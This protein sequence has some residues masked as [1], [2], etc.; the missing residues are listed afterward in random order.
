MKESQE[1]SE[2][3]RVPPYLSVAKLNKLFDLLST[4]S[5]AQITSSDLMAR[6][7]SKQDSFLAVQTLKFFGLLAPGGRT[8]EDIRLF[9]M[10]GPEKVEKLQS[11]FRQSYKKIFDTVPNAEK[12]TKNELHDELMASYKISHRLATPA[13]LAFLW[14]CGKF[15]LETTEGVISRPKSKVELR[16]SVNKNRGAG[17]ISQEKEKPE[18]VEA[19]DKNH[20]DMNISDTGIKVLFPKDEKLEDAIVSGDFSEARLKIIEFAKKVGLVKG[21]RENKIGSEQD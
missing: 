17:I 8:T 19:Q 7:F 2:K 14:L 16:V 18:H 20:F 10:K 11:I 12:L 13:V 5:L 1:T 6:G 9:A 21:D 4:R 15:G 3:K